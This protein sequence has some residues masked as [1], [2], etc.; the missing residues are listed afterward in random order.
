MMDRIE[1]RKALSDL[2]VPSSIYSL[3]GSQ[4]DERVCMLQR[5]NAWLVTFY[6]RGV[7][8]L[9]GSFDTESAACEFMLSELR[10]EASLGR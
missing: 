2:S 4:V 5:D 10:R 8:R 6:E 3:S 1:L 7:E 9:L